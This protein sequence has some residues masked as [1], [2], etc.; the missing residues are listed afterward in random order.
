[1]RQFGRSAIS[2]MSAEPFMDMH[3]FSIT[4]VAWNQQLDTLVFT[5]TENTWCFLVLKHPDLVDRVWPEA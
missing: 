4:P 2:D 1:M 5:F 3:E